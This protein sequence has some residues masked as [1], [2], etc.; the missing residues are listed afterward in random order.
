LEGCLSCFQL[1]PLI[2]VKVDIFSHQMFGL[3]E[4]RQREMA[5]IFFFEVGEEILRWGIVPTVAASGH[6]WGD[7]I[8]GSK[9]MICV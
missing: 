6:G 1:D 3:F 9:D 7:V 2:V 8:L 5:E 4:A